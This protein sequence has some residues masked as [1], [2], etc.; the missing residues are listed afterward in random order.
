MNPDKYALDVSQLKKEVMDALFSSH[1][2]I[3]R[4]IIGEKPQ[5]KRKS[6]VVEN[7]LREKG[8]QNY[9]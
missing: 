1:H 4:D 5:V 3:L 8:I 7:Y 9:L 2:S 6:A